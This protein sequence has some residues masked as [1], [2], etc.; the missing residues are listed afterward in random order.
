M[1]AEIGYSQSG[2]LEKKRLKAVTFEAR[3]GKK[4]ANEFAVG[5]K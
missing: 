4:T 5:V 2:G 3:G 1:E